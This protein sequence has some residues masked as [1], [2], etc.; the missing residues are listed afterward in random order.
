MLGGVW[1]VKMSLLSLA[2]ASGF[3]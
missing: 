3:S 1:L 2:R